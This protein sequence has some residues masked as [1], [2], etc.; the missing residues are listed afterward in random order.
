MRIP[1][2]RPVGDSPSLRRDSECRE[3]REKDDN[4][5]H[6][7]PPQPKFPAT[8]AACRPAKASPAYQCPTGLDTCTAS[9]GQD[10]IHNY[11]DYTVDSCQTEFTPGQTARMNEMW[12]SYR[13][14][15]STAG[16]G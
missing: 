15:G 11:M 2:K 7:D 6:G 1:V 8:L 5:T 3:Q 10:P 14:A 16:R 4:A 12:V 9:A 13:A